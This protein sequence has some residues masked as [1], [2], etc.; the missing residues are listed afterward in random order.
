[1]SLC[2]IISLSQGVRGHFTGMKGWVVFTGI[3]FP[4]FFWQLR[5]LT[6]RPFPKKHLPKS[7]TVWRRLMRIFGTG[8]VM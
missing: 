5:R 3:W 8:W 7:A 4:S 1:M 6:F 2:L